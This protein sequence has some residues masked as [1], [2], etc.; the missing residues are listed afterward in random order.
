MPVVGSDTLFKE[1]D[2]EQERAGRDGTH[3]EPTFPLQDVVLND[4]ITLFPEESEPKAGTIDDGSET[5]DAEEGEFYDET[6]ENWVPDGDHDTVEDDAIASNEDEEEEEEEEEI[7]EDNEKE[8]EE[9]Y[10]ELLEEFREMWKAKTC[11]L[12]DPPFVFESQFIVKF[13]S[14]MGNVHQRKTSKCPLCSEIINNR[15]QYVIHLKREHFHGKF[16]CQEGRCKDR[17]SKPTFGQA[18]DYYKHV[19]DKHGKG[20]GDHTCSGWLSF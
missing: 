15:R 3:T 12:C 11:T 18:K 16:Q 9:E 19:L 17:K 2:Q 1:E 7:P 4:S 5:E 8:D 13:C 20:L 10:P 14:H 6:D